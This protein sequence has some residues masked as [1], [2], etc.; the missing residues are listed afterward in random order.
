V[1][2][3]PSPTPVFVLGIQRSGTT[4]LG[5]ILAEHPD[6]VAVQADDHFGIHE[7]IFFSHFARA[8]GDLTDDA[9]FRRFAADFAASDYYVLTGLEPDWLWRRRPRSYPEAF[10]AVMDE[11]ASRRGGA[12]IWIE[13]SPHHTLLADDLEAAFPD[14]R[15]VCIERRP[16][17]VVASTLRMDDPMPP[18]YPLRLGRVMRLAAKCSLYQR[19]LEQFCRGRSNAIQTRFEV[20]AADPAAEVRRICDFLEVD[21]VPAM[22]ELPWRRNTSFGP[23]SSRR[24]IMDPLEAGVVTTVTAAVRPIPV[25]RRRSR[26]LGR[27]AARGI[28]WP[29]WCWR[30]RGRRQ[31][32]D[33][34]TRPSAPPPRSA[35]HR[36]RLET[37]ARG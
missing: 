35:E 20:L 6:A 16:D 5:N 17:A 9:D 7:S 22:L 27:L 13:K 10:R 4:W 1:S 3:V 11:M 30:R 24:R 34:L 33:T 31:L 8:Y 2:S 29:D 23:R 32:T 28:V 12:R 37:T 25:S 36:Q 19:W 18:A 15:F 21:F 14:A 26:E